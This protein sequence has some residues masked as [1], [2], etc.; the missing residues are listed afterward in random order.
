MRSIFVELYENPCKSSCMYYILQQDIL[1]TVAQSL[2]G[3]MSP[4]IY[5][6]VLRNQGRPWIIYFNRFQTGS[7]Y[8][9]M[10]YVITDANYPT[11]SLIVRNTELYCVHCRF[12]LSIER[13]F[14]S[15]LIGQL[16]SAFVSLQPDNV[17]T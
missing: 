15:S 5:S 1:I 12:K 11:I 9:C 8:F 4:S 16:S 14:K 10:N 17:P 13:C 7:I 6:L 2:K 3:C